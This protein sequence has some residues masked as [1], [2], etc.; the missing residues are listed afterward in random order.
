MKTK[1]KCRIS[2]NLE[3]GSTDD[4]RRKSEDVYFSVLDLPQAYG[5]LPLSPDTK[6]RRNLSLIGG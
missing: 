1:T 6:V 5:Q 2:R 3:H 4:E